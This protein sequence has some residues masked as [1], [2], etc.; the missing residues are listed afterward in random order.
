VRRLPIANRPRFAYEEV[1]RPAAATWVLALASLP[2]HCFCPSR[3]AHS[4]LPATFARST[5]SAPAPRVPPLHRMSS[6]SNPAASHKAVR[7]SGASLMDAATI[8]IY[9]CTLSSSALSFITTGTIPVSTLPFLVTPARAGTRHRLAPHNLA[10]I[11]SPR[12]AAP[13]GP[14]AASCGPARLTPAVNE[15]EAY[16]NADGGDVGANEDN[17]PHPAGAASSE[18]PWSGRSSAAQRRDPPR[19]PSLTSLAINIIV[20]QLTSTVIESTK[21]R[22]ATLYTIPVANI[23]PP[24]HHAT[25]RGPGT[26]EISR[27]ILLLTIVAILWHTGP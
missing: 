16:R 20:S 27:H 13:F 8:P 6:T 4:N 26:R 5:A 11:A 10:T 22:I 12:F 1:S 15:D 21:G 18:H 17:K 24:K 7:G 3:P 2:S 19:P 14:C 23:P 25:Q 9:S